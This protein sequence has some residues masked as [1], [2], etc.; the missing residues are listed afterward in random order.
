MYKLGIKNGK[1]NV[2]EYSPVWTP[3]YFKEGGDTY[4]AGIPGILAW[5]G[6]ITVVLGGGV[7]AI[8]STSAL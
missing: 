8:V 7:A 2:D 4:E 3:E 1:A 5:L 6:V